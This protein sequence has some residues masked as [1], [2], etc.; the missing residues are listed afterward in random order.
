MVY[1]NG[2]GIKL[3]AK[4]RLSYKARG[5]AVEESIGQ[6]ENMAFIHG[7]KVDIE[8]KETYTGSYVRIQVYGERLSVMN[9]QKEAVPYLESMKRETEDG[10][11]HTS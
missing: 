3:T 5:V 8:Q 2:K 1:G 7:V 10:P 9:F 11:I 4:L 6:L